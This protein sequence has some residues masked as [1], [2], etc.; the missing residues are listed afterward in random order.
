MYELLRQKNI[1]LQRLPVGLDI[2]LKG[3]CDCKLMCDNDEA[4][5][6]ILSQRMVDG[7]LEKV[8][9]INDVFS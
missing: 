3:M 6:A 2:A 5:H 4:C 8:P 7:A 9:I 1:H